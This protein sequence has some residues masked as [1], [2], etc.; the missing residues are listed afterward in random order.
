VAKEPDIRD[1]AQRN[2]ILRRLVEG[3]GE[4][5]LAG[6]SITSLAARRTLWR[7]NATIQKVYFP[8]TG[9]ISIIVNT[10]AGEV[11]EMATVGNE[12][13]VGVPISIGVNRAIGRA[14]VQSPGEAI[15]TSAARFLDLA[16]G[17]PAVAL[18]IDRYTYFFV[19]L[20]VQ[21]GL[22]YRFHSAEERCARWLLGV[23]DRA[24][25]DEFAF[26]QDFLAL[27]MGTRRPKAN[28]TLATLRRAGAID[29]SYRRIA[30]L[31]RGALE[32]FSCPCY[33]TMRQLRSD[34]QLVTGPL[35]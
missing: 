32:S 27:M 14:L 17:D 22:C 24:G 1:S 7:Q 26:T 12:G 13:V 25:T 20:L 8:L 31:D 28:L 34:L 10:S 5:R 15:V 6:F 29:Y 33:E 18:I 19:R 11:M 30:I 9:V 3:H 23:H 35:A 2:S 21:T 4:R 16:T